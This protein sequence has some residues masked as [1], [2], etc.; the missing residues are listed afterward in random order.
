VREDSILTSRQNP[1]DVVRR[2]TATWVL[3]GGVIVA[4]TAV[5]LTLISNSLVHINDDLTTADHS[6]T[7][8]SGHTRTLPDQIQNLNASLDR[9][10]TAL[11]A[12]PADSGQIV[13]HLDSV[14][15][16]L[17]RIRSDLAA[18]DPELQRTAANLV[19]SDTALQPIGSAVHDTADLL[20]QVLTETGAMRSTMSG[21]IGTG[22]TGLAG[23]HRNLASIEA[24]LHAVRGDLG[25]ILR[26]DTRV[27]GD[28]GRVCRS[29]AVN[30]L[31]GPQPC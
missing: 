13:G 20:A 25:N 2:W 24:V 7:D 15:A 31:H 23:V 28:L 14:T 26:A 16:S 4:V 8:V 10:E 30:L 5:F 11:H 18:A 9:I 21:I 3:I 6:V 27:N 1:G 29:V 17:E 12:L 22:T 19:V